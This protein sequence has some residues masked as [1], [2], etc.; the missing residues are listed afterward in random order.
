MHRKLLTVF[1]AVAAAVGALLTA[2][3]VVF[4]FKYAD[5]GKDWV[6][7]L[8]PLALLLVGAAGL[9]L[10]LRKGKEEPPA[11]EEDDEAEEDV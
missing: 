11:D 1:F 7:L 9:L 8:I 3:T 5:P 6:F 10:R 2:L 4:L